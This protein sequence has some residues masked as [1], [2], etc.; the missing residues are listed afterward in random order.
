MYLAEVFGDH[1]VLQ[2]DKEICIFGYGKGKGTIEF[3]GEKHSFISESDKFRI[4]LSPRKAGGPFEMKVTLNGVERVI[5]DIMIGDV[6]IAGGQSNIEFCLGQT[7]NIEY[8]F[9]KNIRFFTEPNSVDEEG[10]YI[11]FSSDWF[12]CEGKAVDDFSAIGYYFALEC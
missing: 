2:R 7:A 8:N 1:M 6:Y 12:I 9:N 11:H 10:N 5:N 4:Y 3:C